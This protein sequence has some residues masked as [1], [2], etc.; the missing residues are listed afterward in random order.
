MLNTNRMSIDFIRKLSLI[1]LVFTSL[2]ASASNP[3]NIVY[4]VDSRPQKKSPWRGE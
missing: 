3:V 1:T 2:S 4:R